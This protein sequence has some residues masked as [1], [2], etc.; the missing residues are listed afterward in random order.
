MNFEENK[1]NIDG[2]TQSEKNIPLE[3]DVESL[4]SLVDLCNS[5][6]FS[7]DTIEKILEQAFKQPAPEK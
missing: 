3:T 1:T 2:E 7:Q 6:Q 4:K 5:G